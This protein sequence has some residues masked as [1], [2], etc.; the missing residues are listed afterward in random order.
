MTDASSRMKLAELS[1][2]AGAGILGVGLGA[3][4]ASPL[5]GFGIPVLVLGLVLHA[6][7]MTDKHRLEHGAI[8]PRWSIA[9]YWLCWLALAALVLVIAVRAIR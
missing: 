3:L 2:T 4:L 5:R 8:G 1:S 7:G 9:L 6:W